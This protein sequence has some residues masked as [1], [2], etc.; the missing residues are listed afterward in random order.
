MVE[1]ESLWSISNKYYLTPLKW[2]LI[3]D[4]NNISE[5]KAD[6]LTVG[7]TINIPQL[8]ERKANAKYHTRDP[9]LENNFFIKKGAKLVHVELDGEHA[10]VDVEHLPKRTVN[11]VSLGSNIKIDES[12]MRKFI[13][14]I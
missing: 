12:L 6:H 13:K 7:L 3:A 8:P 4:K 10:I 2:K 14:G 9:R 11:K 1:G 5:S